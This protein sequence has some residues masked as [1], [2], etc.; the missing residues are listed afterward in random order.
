[1]NRVSQSCVPKVKV[2]FLPATQIMEVPMDPEIERVVRQKVERGDYPSVA[3]MVEE[4][5]YLL[6]ERD[7]TRSQAELQDR[8]PSAFDAISETPLEG[9]Q[10]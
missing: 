6:V 9:D 2:S 10:P 4:A 3:V 5:L 1:M 8:V 7:W